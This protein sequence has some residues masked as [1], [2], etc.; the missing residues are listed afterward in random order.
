MGRV[1]LSY[2]REDVGTAKQLAMVIGAAGHH[3]WWDREIQGGSHFSSEIDKELK[4]ADAV[5]VLWSE[6]AIAS[7]WVQDEAAEGRD[8]GRLVP[9][10]IGA[11]KPPLGFR[12]FQ[13]VDFANWDGSDDSAALVAMR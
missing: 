6:A 9:I 4:A 5:V 12:Q 13:A 8:S 2:A 11:E 10:L 3:V 1:F 7:P